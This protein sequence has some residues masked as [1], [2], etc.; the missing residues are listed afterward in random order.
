[1]CAMVERNLRTGTS[2]MNSTGLL[3]FDAH[4]RNILTDGRRLYFADFGLAMSPRFE[5]SAAEVDFLGK[6]MSH[7]GCYTV[8]QLVNWLVTA[9][10]GAV[11]RTDR[12]EFIRRCAEG[13]EP[14][15]VPAPA[16]AV[17]KRYAPVAVVMNEFYGKLYLESR[18]TPYP[19]DEIQRV[20]A[21]TGFEPT[22]SSRIPT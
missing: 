21:T 16:A 18:T 19:V 17:I 1:M 6:N 14:A 9:L 7:D 8:T 22:L 4:F 10:A 15:N 13:G 11:D 5:L 2:F 3:H 12:I 20:C